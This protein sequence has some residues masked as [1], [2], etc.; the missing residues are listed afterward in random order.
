ME[1]NT[2]QA[3]ISALRRALGEAGARHVVTVAG[4]GYRLSDKDIV[5]NAE[6]SPAPPERASIAVLPF[7]NMS[8][9]PEQ[10]YFADGIVEDITTALSRVRW[11][12]VIARN[13]SFTYKGRVVD[14]RT[15]GRELGVRYILEGS[16]RKAMGRVRITGQLIEAETRA[17][18]WADRF[19]GDFQDVFSLQDQVT[20]NIVRA[21]AP[22]LRHAELE[23]VRRKRPE[24]MDAYDLYLRALPPWTRQGNEEAMRLLQQALSRDPG[25]APALALQGFVLAHASAQGWIQPPGSRHAEV[26]ELA[27]AAVR[28]E[29]NDADVVA[30]ASHLLAYCSHEH[31]EATRLAQRGCA[32]GPN[33]AF[34]WGQAGYALFHTGHAE[35]AVACFKHA[36]RLDPVDPMG[37]STMGGLTYALLSLGENAEA[38]ETASKAVQQNRNYTFA[39]RGLAAALALSGRLVEGR[40]ALEEMLRVEPNFSIAALLARTPSAPKRFGPVIQ[41]LRLLGAPE[42]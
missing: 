13:S 18:V 32:L 25:Y 9:D 35:E 11:L 16:V 4:R 41:G 15:I 30:G 39:W 28:A 6:P 42:Q 3:Q 8:G 27:R 5:A 19:D 14:V 23:R 33:S 29:P 26:V 40:R 17:H 24:N 10:D 31:D 21:I 7:V 22:T 20:D 34:A 1:E 2:L 37:F 36:M 38:I 12:F